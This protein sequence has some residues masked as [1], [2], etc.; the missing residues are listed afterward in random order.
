MAT[1]TS[2]RVFIWVIAIVMTVGTLAGF[3]AM[4]IA[5]GNQKVDDNQKQILTEQYQAEVQAQTDELS[6]QYYGE[7]SKYSTQPTTFIAEDITMLGMKDLKIG[8]GATITEGTS[9]SAYYI[10]WNPT[11]TVFDQSIEGA[12]LKKPIEGGNLIEGWN[13]GVI[14]MKIGGVREIAIPSDQAYAEKGSG[15]NIPPNT[16]I[17][18]VVMAIPTPKIIQPSAELLKYYAQ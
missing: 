18:F 6:K 13:T 16:P 1:K 3:I 15:A 17:K 4:M 10:G 2:Q 8:D 14:G 11:G 9:Y 5:P 12:K 7:F